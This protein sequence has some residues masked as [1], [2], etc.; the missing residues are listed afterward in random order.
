M[1]L[2]RRDALLALAGAD[3]QYNA[4]THVMTIPV[5]GATVVQTM[6]ARR[7]IRIGVDPVTL[8]QAATI[9]RN[10]LARTHTADPL[11]FSSHAS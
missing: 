5:R 4:A 3:S 2:N 6:S 8:L 7:E 1:F 11:L 9:D 10:Q